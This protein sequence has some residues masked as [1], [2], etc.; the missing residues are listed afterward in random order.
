MKIKKLKWDSD[1]FGFGIADL[2]EGRIENIDEL[3]IKGDIKLIWTLVGADNSRYINRLT[4]SG[5]EFVDL[6]LTFFRVACATNT[7]GTRL[8]TKNDLPE[9]IKLAGQAF[10]KD[11]R[12]NHKNFS[13]QKTKKLYELWVEKSVAGS[14]DDCCFVAEVE[15]EIAGFAT[16]KKISRSDS[17]IGLIATSKK[18]QNKGIGSKLILKCLDFAHS[19]KR[20]TLLVGT[21]GKNI[22]AQNFYIKNGFKI[23]KIESW[24]YKWI[25]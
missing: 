21:E 13:Q 6:R 2:L 17:S 16:Y 23:K 8:A 25:N 9:L 14:F 4:Q 24:Y 11:S 20:K 5:F 7:E 19:Q 22:A 12:F 3:T 1:F 10:L 18:F 15:G